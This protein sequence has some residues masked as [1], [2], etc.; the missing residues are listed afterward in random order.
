MSAGPNKRYPR[1]DVP[2]PAG[3]QEVIMHAFETFGSE[4]RAWHWLE[5]PNLFAG[6]APIDILQTD[7]GIYELVEDELMRTN[8]GVFV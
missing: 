6:A 1:K 2:M 8:Y 4:E 5:R 3:A 7:P